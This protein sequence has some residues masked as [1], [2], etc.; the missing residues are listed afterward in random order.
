MPLAVNGDN[1]TI[2]ITEQGKTVNYFSNRSS[3]DLSEE[4]ETSDTGRA[5]TI[6]VMDG[7]ISTSYIL[8][9]SGTELSISET[10]IIEPAN[11]DGTVNEGSTVTLRPIVTGG[12]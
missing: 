2:T 12:S 11:E 10:F 7:D 8:G 9:V 3:G 1:A 6:K 4:I 5:L